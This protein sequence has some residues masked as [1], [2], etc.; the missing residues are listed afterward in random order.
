MAL[1]LSLTAYALRRNCSYSSVRNKVFSGAISDAVK[2]NADGRMPGIDADEADRL[3]LASTDPALQGRARAGQEQDTVFKHARAARARVRNEIAQ[4][5][6]EEKVSKLV[7]AAQAAS[8]FGAVLRQV[9]DALMRNFQSADGLL[10][11]NPQ[12]AQTRAAFKK[13]WHEILGSV[14]REIQVLDVQ[15]EAAEAKYRQAPPTGRVKRLCH[16]Q[17]SQPAWGHE[18]A[19]AARGR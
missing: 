2:R 7:D 19:I 10:S 6:L 1:L 9:R 13:C 14:D 15:S 12:N 5:E 4:I 8:E 18:P 11:T 16:P 17:R 3:W